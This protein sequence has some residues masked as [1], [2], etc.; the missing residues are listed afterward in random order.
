MIL[1]TAGR[2]RDQFMGRLF[3]V[4]RDTGFNGA[5]KVT[6]WRYEAPHAYGYRMSEIWGTKAEAAR[7]ARVYI[8]SGEC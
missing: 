2:Y 6:G 4:Y 5:V 3:T 1:V 8:S 7:A